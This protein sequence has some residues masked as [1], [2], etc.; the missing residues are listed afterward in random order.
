MFKLDNGY[1]GFVIL[2]HHLISDAAT[3]G[4]IGTE[5]AENYYKL[6]INEDIAPKDF[7][8]EDYILSEKEYMESPKFNTSKEYWEKIYETIPE[9]SS[10]PSIYKTASKDQGLKAKRKDFLI[11]TPLLRRISNFC[12]AHKL[13]NFN[14]FMAIFAIY[15]GKIT[16]LTDFSIGTPILNRTGFKE[17]HTTGMFIN[18]AALRI[19]LDDNI[20]FTDFAKNI[21]EISLGMLRH[22]K[23]PYE[24]LLETLRKKDSHLPNLYDIALSY[25]I[26]KAHN[27]EALL[28]YEVKWYPT[29]SI[30][31][32]LNIHL[33]DNNDEE[34]LNISYDY[35]I[36]KYD[37]KDIDDMHSHIIHLI[38]QVL[39]NE[40]MLQKDLELVTK[41]EK[42]ILLNKF[43]DTKVGYPKDK[44]I[45]E[46]FE[47]QVTRAPNDI[48]VVFE[49]KK[50]T[51]KELNE[52]ANSLAIEL[53][54]N[55]LN[56]GDVIGI[57]LE[58]SLELIISIFACI[59]SKITYVLIEK[60][61]P[62]E[63]IRYILENSNSKLLLT[64]KNLDTENF[65]I[66]ALLI[67]NCTNSV[68]S[69]DFDCENLSK[70]SNLCIIYTSGSTGTPKGVLLTQAGFINLV[71]AM[72]DAMNL[73]IC[74]RFISHASVSFD[75]F[76]FELYC[77]ILNGKT[78]YLT[79]DLEQKDSI[80]ISNIII[81]NNIDF[82]LSTPSKIE[83]LLA[84]DDLAKSLRN[85]KVFLL[86][87]EVFT[88]NLY[89]R[90]R[91]K[92]VGNIYNG[93]GPTEI[94]AC[95]SIKKIESEDNINIGKPVNNAQIY[96]LNNK[97]SLCP[98]G[99]IGE[100]CVA[101]DGL[102][103]CYI[104][105]KE[106]TDKAF[107][108]FPSANSTIYKTGDL[109]RFTTNGE[110]EYIGRHDF[111]VK[112]HGQRIEL[113]EIERKI[114]EI[115]A[116]NNICVCIKQLYGRDIL[117]AYYTI[118][119]DIDKQSIKDALAK[120]LPKY[121]IPTYFLELDELPLT[122]NG[123]VDR[124]KLPAPALKSD[125]EII[126]PINNTEE[127][128]LSLF[129]ELL[130]LERISTTDSFFELRRRFLACY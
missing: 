8:Y 10:I 17:K 74:N 120:T 91:D 33:H 87:G 94:T 46:L 47:E 36:D 68:S 105:D 69:I 51:Y 122:S 71:F 4:L 80:S 130:G 35:K 95:C 21:A 62:S 129:K 75:M 119:R 88:S 111:Q 60:T 53:L 55:K 112:L 84:N 52:K 16:D 43:N 73:Q 1:G 107:V 24:M 81:N 89:N 29:S 106:R 93:Y 40:D 31:S 90:M 11:D 121:M 86:G 77:S 15:I 20:S 114:S 12:Y 18:T 41:E 124:T 113:E 97:L 54:K 32:S 5:I 116:I 61:L 27:K 48:A 2:T 76:A 49:D 34:S 125:E 127:Q 78:L 38:S 64:S 117:C 118:N 102:A 28:P 57:R 96:I 67:D 101:G 98:I 56:I 109:A 42:D 6:G 72:N 126:G 44:T 30:S 79:N 50:L 128:L 103:S 85:I 66:K 63:R 104:N 58:R 14:F 83:L 100:L 9:V 45:I 26:T 13:S 65:G 92:T 22:Q 37:E 23:Y 70:N 99:H 123:K 108:N 110:I 3:F 59:K 82:M 19:K 39:E 7:S 25:Q 115:E